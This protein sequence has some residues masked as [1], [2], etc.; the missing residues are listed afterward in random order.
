MT[1]ARELFLL[2]QERLNKGLLD[3][4]LEAFRQS[5]QKNEVDF[6]LQLQ[7]GKLLLYGKDDDDD[8]IDLR[9]AEKHLLLAARFADAEKNSLANWRR[10]CG[11]AYF[12][13][14][15]TAY[16]LGEQEKLISQQ[17]GMKISLER[18]LGYLKRSLNLWPEFLES[19]YVQAKCHALLGHAAEA[20]EKLGVLSD[21]DRKYFAKATQDRD[22]DAFRVEV[23]NVFR[24]AVTS[25]GS[26]ARA[27]EGKIVKTKE[28]LEWAELGT[29]TSRA[30]FKMVE[31]SQW[32]VEAA[33]EALLST[34]VDIVSLAA[35]LDQTRHDLVDATDR[36][37][38]ER[39]AVLQSDL[40]AQAARKRQMESN[41][42]NKHCTTER[43]CG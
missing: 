16:L 12:H 7:I 24:R 42:P 32:V 11:E 40:S 33:K 14:A 39:L 10:Y 28:A 22:F 15:I 35:Q 21:H 30:D 19:V 13:A 1:Q 43:V 25:P 3:K 36:G 5:E 17:D 31:R 26:F 29:R 20:Q 9:E 2:G 38:K 18:A 6:L 23:D 37:Y 8:I 4:A 41:I 27:T 34:D